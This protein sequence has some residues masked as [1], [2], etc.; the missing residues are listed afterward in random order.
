MILWFS[1]SA[2]IYAS[3]ILA[4]RRF[5]FLSD[6][7]HIPTVDDRHKYVAPLAVGTAKEKRVLKRQIWY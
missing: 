2:T 7:M 1:S 5:L 6:I 3:G 4:M